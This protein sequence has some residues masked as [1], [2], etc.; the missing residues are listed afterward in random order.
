MAQSIK[1]VIFAPIIITITMK[2]IFL[3]LSLAVMTAA[4]LAI[5]AKPGQ[6]ITIT[7][8]D[9]TTVKVEKRGDEFSNFYGS[10]DGRLFIRD[11]RTGLYEETTIEKISS[12]TTSRRVSAQSG[13]A[14]RTAMAKAAAKSGG[15]LYTGE[16]KGLVILVQFDDLKFNENYTVELFDKILNEEGFSNDMGF[17]G[18]VRDYYRDQSFGQFDLSFDVVGPV[19]M[20]YGYAH[21]GKPTSYYDSDDYKA[22][23]EMVVM[24]CEEIDDQVDFNDYDWDGDG[25]AD[26]VVIIY[27]GHG[28]A[29]YN[30]P[31]T[32][33]PH[34]WNIYEAS[35]R[36]MNPVFDGVKVNT[37]ACCNELNERSKIEGI[38]TI[39]HE[40]AHCLG[41]P[42]L[43]DTWNGSLFG[44]DVWSL[45][46]SGNYNGG[47]F[48]PASLTT[49]ER[50]LAGWIT[51]TE[52]TEYRE[53]NGMKAMSDGGETFIIYND[54][55]PD[56]HYLLENRQLK[57]WDAGLPGAGLLIIH[58][59]YDAEKWEYN[60]VNA[61]AKQGCTIF[62]ADNNTLRTT[63]GRK[64][65]IYPYN[66]N[67][68][69]TDTSL[70]AATLNNRSAA[71][72][73]LM[74]KPITNIQRNDDGTISFV[75]GENTSAV[76]GLTTDSDNQLD[77]PVYS[78]DGRRLNNGLD[79]LKKGVYIVNGK[80]IIR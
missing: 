34:E 66:S 29:N 37:Y 17:V 61:Y 65:D 54:A 56:E 9:G 6:W 70:P 50:M 67:N 20:P 40:F 33:W 53:V 8:A 49:H 19:T 7:L 60:L 39:C 18:S 73:Y 51:P 32:I 52:L 1:S 59:D 57:G 16:K 76:K 38:G 11:A 74:G 62:H 2:K 23:A 4:A 45:L 77:A 47:S 63:N 25:E 21:Y 14:R 26:Q 58:V 43:Y 36:T 35:N 12:A 5:P 30:D 10:E 68:S 80:K 75:F 28:E 41:L 42:D 22:I 24:A 44:M 31:N 48:I 71:G 13:T 3:T 79:V 72:N 15:S 27:A 46:A 55:H 69:L 64:G 78:I